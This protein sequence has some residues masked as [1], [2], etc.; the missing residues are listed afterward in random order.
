[1]NLLIIRH[2][3]S[4]ADILNVYEGRADFALTELGHK[5]ATQMAKWV[6]SYMKPD[7]IY[8][9]TLQ[10]ARQTAEKLSAATGIPIQYEDALMEWNNG[11]IAGLSKDEASKKYP[12]PNP[13]FPHTAMYNQES[14]IDFR[15][16]AE[17]ILSKIINENLP[18]SKIA[19]VSHGGMISRLFQSFMGLPMISN[20]FIYSGDTGV[21]HLQIDT[22]AVGD[23]RNR[24]IVFLNSQA[25]LAGSH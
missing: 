15:T 2:G 6:G 21:H 12:Q 3:Q 7:K 11:L 14:D 1:M 9:S 23:S 20:T 18:E 19:I 17:T 16:R 22:S 8:A 10:R 25:H 24:R 4:E 13:K 5:Q